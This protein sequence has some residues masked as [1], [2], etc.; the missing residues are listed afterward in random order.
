MAGGLDLG[1]LPAA[2]VRVGPHRIRLRRTCLVLGVWHFL[3][4]HV[5]R[6][7]VLG[8]DH[9]ESVGGR[10]GR[11]TLG[12]ERGHAVQHGGGDDDRNARAAGRA[13]F[14]ALDHDLRARIRP[15]PGVDGHAAGRQVARLDGDLDLL[16]LLGAPPTENLLAGTNGNV[17]AVAVGVMHQ[18]MGGR[19]VVAPAEGVE[20]DDR[21]ALAA[22]GHA[23]RLGQTVLPMPAQDQ[24][25]LAAV[26]RRVEDPQRDAAQ[27]EVAQ[28][29]CGGSRCRPGRSIR[30]RRRPPRRP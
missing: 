17:F 15:G 1:T 11:A 12:S 4:R 22:D 7:K 24:A 27:G 18:V 30:P 29:A 3:G 21:R 25:A 26:G 8:L 5:A 20:E 23:G 16:V 9:H 2:E 13:E 28:R 10:L 6:G 19:L 14:D